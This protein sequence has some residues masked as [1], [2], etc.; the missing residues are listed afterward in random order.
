MQNRELVKIGK[1]VDLPLTGALPF[2]VIDR[3]TNLLQI[4][5]VSGCNLSCPFCSV[6]EGPI[7]DKAARYEV[8][9]D[10]MLEYAKA[11]A[12]R[13]ESR[14]LEMHIDGCGEPLLYPKTVE[15]VEG[16]SSLDKTEVVSLQTNGTLL[17]EEKISKLEDAGLDRMNLTINSLEEKLAVELAGTEDYDLEAVLESAERVARGETDL[18]IAPVWIE[19]VTGAEIKKIIEYAKEIG[20][21]ESW[22]S[23]GIQ[24]YREHKNGRKV[25]SSEE[26]SW[27]EFF[28]NL[29]KLEKKHGI[30][31]GLKPR[32]FDMKKVG[33]ALP[34]VFER[35]EKVNMKVLAQGWNPGQKLA[36]SN[37]RTVTVVNGDEVSLG[38]DAR[39]E[40][41][42]NRHNL[43]L[44]MAV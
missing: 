29:E 16:L 7:G 24:K 8:S 9:L 2:G 40:I 10:Y 44:G 23:L 34:K 41:L 14:R 18:L 3:G 25:D 42:R 30:K 11:V 37:H 38:Q 39:V 43:Y 1:E 19:G 21:G 27:K 31:L 6:D 17:D 20:A 32:D 35:G 33:F 28:E 26:V 4:R 22:P 12:E 15:L 13:K 36:V 5:P